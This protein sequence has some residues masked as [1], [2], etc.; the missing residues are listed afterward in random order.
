MERQSLC[1]TISQWPGARL[2]SQGFEEG[3]P[4][5]AKPAAGTRSQKS[6]YQDSPLSSTQGDW[7]KRKNENVNKT[8]SNETKSTLTNQ[9]WKL[10]TNQPG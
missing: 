1:C 8:Q 7:F 2:T 10:E 3:G 5:V 6:P 9:I 4:S